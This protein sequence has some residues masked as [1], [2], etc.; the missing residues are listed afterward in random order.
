MIEP[1]LLAVILTV[2]ASIIL[3]FFRI[4]R[5]PTIFDRIAAADSIGVLFLLV[6][7]L[8]SVYFDRPAFLD[9]A[10]VYGILLFMGVLMFARYFAKRREVKED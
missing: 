7:V 9:V 6:L 10:L 2:V 1:I 4:L 8:L 3:I 5:G